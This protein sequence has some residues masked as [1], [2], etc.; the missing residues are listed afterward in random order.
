MDRWSG[1]ENLFGRNTH[2]YVVK[3][4]SK[5]YEESVFDCYFATCVQIATIY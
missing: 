1:A 2:D 5:F 3:S 4:L